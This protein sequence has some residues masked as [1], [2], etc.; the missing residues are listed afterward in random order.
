MEFVDIKGGGRAPVLGLGT[1]RLYN[2]ECVRAVRMA[3]DLGYR[4]IDTAELYGNERAIGEAIATSGVERAEIFLTTKIWTNHFRAADARRA[5]EASLR[6][7][8]M[9]YVDLLLMHSPNDSVPLAETLGALASLREVG[10]ARAIGVSNFPVLL[11]EK[12]I[13]ASPAPIACNQV[14]YYV[15]FDQK[16]LLAFARSRDIVVTAYSPLGLGSLRYHPILKDIAGKHGKNPGQIAL[17]WLI[18]QHGVTAI[19]KATTEKN[20]RANIDIFDFALDDEDR[21]R[22]EKAHSPG[23][24]A[25]IATLRRFSRLL[26]RQ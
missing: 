14:K 5:A 13:S 3:L 12:A 11:L 17:R 21:A 16:P 4:H 23:L 9:D 7:L 1:A 22:L 15:S 6:N 19:P 10:Q 25:R 26:R 18:E 2:S 8:R 20:L 24:L